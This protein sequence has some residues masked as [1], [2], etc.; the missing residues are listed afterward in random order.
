MI[1]GSEDGAY[2]FAC[3]AS[4]R[5]HTDVRVLSLHDD[6]AKRWDI[7]MQQKQLEVAFLFQG[8]KTSGIVSKPDLVTKNPE[9]AMRDA[10]MVVFMAHA[11]C[12]QVY[13]EALAP[14]I[15]PGTII[16]GLPGN[17]EFESQVRH[18]LGE[19]AQQCTIMNFESLPWT[20]QTSESGVACEVVHTMDTLMGNMMVTHLLKP[21]KP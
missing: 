19:K 16:I 2:V 6:E 13:L 14:H 8:E 5:K 10:E 4:S 21:F 1:C 3:I 20:C 17:P 12:L 18:V 11:S 15:K 7:A 9:D